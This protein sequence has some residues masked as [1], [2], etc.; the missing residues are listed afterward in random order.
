M[1]IAKLFLIFAFAGAGFFYFGESLEADSASVIINEIAWMGTAISANSEWL[2]LKNNSDSEVDLTGWKLAALD[3]TP[4]ISLAGKIPAKGYFLLERTSDDSAPG[5]AADQIYTGALSNSGEVLE[6]RDSTGNLIDKIDASV[7]WPAGDNTSKKT[8]ERKEDGAWQTS[9][10]AGGTPQK[11][12]S[13]NPT[14]PLLPQDNNNPDEEAPATNGS[15][16]YNLGDVVI[17]EFVS[18]PSDGEEE[19]VELYNIYS[20]AIV[21]DGWTIEEGSGAKTSLSGEIGISGEN[22][23]FVLEKPKGNLNNKGDIIILRD[24]NGNLIDQV[25]Y[26]D[27]QDG[28]LA[29]N[30]PVA[31]DPDGVARKIDG[32]NS[33]N[34]ANDFSVTA[35]LTKGRSNV[36]TLE[37]ELEIG[38]LGAGNYDYLKDIT[39]SEV[40]PNPAG[41]DVKGEFIELYNMGNRDVDLTAWR[42]EDNG[43]NEYQFGAVSA[44]SSSA[45]IKASGYFVIMR[46]ES[47]IALNNDSDSVK[48]FQPLKEKPLQTVKY[49]KAVE[50]WSYA[51]SRIA[52]N[53]GQIATNNKEWAWSET[54]TPG[55]SNE[56]KTVNHPPVV[57]FDCP[58]QA[59]TGANI[60]FDSSDTIDEDGD[61]LIYVWDFGDGV[62]NS[63]PSPEHAF[64]KKGL[65]TVKLAV[66]DGK[67]EVKKEKVIKV[68][69]VLVLAAETSRDEAMPRLYGGDIIINEFLP[70]PAGSDADGEWIE[71]YNQGEDKVN[72]LSWKLDDSEGGSKPYKF[73]SDFWL[74]GGMFYVLDRPESGLA[75]N[76]TGD[77]VRLYNDLDE[78]AD[79]VEYGAAMEGNS[80]ALEANGKWVW[81]SVLTPGSENVIT[82]DNQAIKQ[83]SDKTKKSGLYVKTTLEKIKEFEAGDLVE[84][85][86]TV[87]VLPGIFGS[88]YFYIVGPS[89]ASTAEASSPGIQIYNYKKE[90]P[91]LKIGDYIEA[92]GELST[93]NGEMRLKTKIADDIK[94]IEHRDEPS[95]EE[96]SSDKLNDDYVGQLV[97]IAGEITEKKSSVIY[98]DDGLGEAV[99][100][101]KKN[102]GINSSDFNEGEAIAVAGIVSRSSS[103]LRI[104]PRSASDIRR[105][106]DTGEVQVLGASS[107]SDEWGIKARNKKILYYV[108]ISL[109]GLVIV[110][111][112]IWWKKFRKKDML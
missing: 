36:I 16:N 71:L 48:L 67:N 96:I 81:T 53:S 77:A 88:Q 17:N 8:M 93:V 102:T 5:V 27:W 80:Y 6:L 41:D 91:D 10:E 3:G 97:K 12:N 24:L 111:G 70:S 108:L 50:G 99:V 73:L 105:E 4:D 76:N 46:N 100:Q 42:L 30:A 101:I 79:E 103:G 11:E 22:K 44:T 62:K 106:N 74:E 35:T 112:A 104:L 38:E 49:K 92:R 63:L 9:Q 65:F 86:G 25:A 78:L 59:L 94:L 64:L 31:G 109:G 57:A 72:L 2:E 52:A 110:A 54:V 18:D 34:N 58:E 33:F 7:G 55:K 19:W 107:E 23:F 98:L 75:L 89:G 68:V 82:A 39:I 40:F 85:A 29:N 66:S 47:K 37:E 28:A 14:P 45:V 15:S 95:P 56:I 84:V 87:A 83:P 90:F 60:V 32:Q 13:I 20:K 61:S 43:G 21:L 69:D 26:G 1:K 51:N